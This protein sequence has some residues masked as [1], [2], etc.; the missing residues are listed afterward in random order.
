[1]ISSI[2]WKYP[3]ISFVA[4]LVLAAAPALFRAGTSDPAENHG[5]VSYE[6]V[7]IGVALALIVVFSARY[8]FVATRLVEG[9]D[10]FFYV[11]VARDYLGSSDA[12][13][14]Y[15]PGGYRF[16]EAAMALFGDEL[17]TLQRVFSGV[18]AANALLVAIVLATS[19]RSLAAATLGALWYLVLASRFEG[20]YGTTEPIATLFALIGLLAWGGRPL[21]G[22]AGWWRAISFGAMLG[23]AT[24]TK[25]P[26][27]LLSLGAAALV[28]SLPFARDERRHD[29]GQLT[30][31][32]V[33][34]AVVLVGALLLEG[35]GLLPVRVG[36]GLPARYESI[37]SFAANVQAMLL[38]MGSAQWVT[39]IALVAWAAS[40]A[41]RSLRSMHS[42][43]W[44]A[45]VAFCWLASLASL[46]QFEKRPYLHYALLAAP[47]VAIAVVGM[48]FGMLRFV[49]AR[50]PRASPFAAT[51]FA[52]I[53][54]VPAI[55]P[56]GGPLQIWPLTW[57]P[58]VAH[59]IPWHESADVASDLRELATLVRPGDELLVLPPRHLAVHFLLRNWS[60]S[61][62]RGWGDADVSD[63]ITP[64]LDAVVT[65]H[66]RVLDETDVETCKSMR[67]GSAA[68]LLPERGFRKVA[69]LKAMTL[70][71]RER[72]ATRATGSPRGSADDP[73]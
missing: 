11:C 63:V 40:L 53:L 35:K 42:E 59:G 7:L 68:A 44:A 41:I 38:A 23:L 12:K 70:W 1:M 72:G 10:F 39:L 25:Q 73:R 13:Y 36:L 62:A 5:R 56:T 9:V 46:A 57:N 34:A 69:E 31:I 4:L 3:Y 48:T 65:L 52:G 32:P 33:A 27:G 30:A 61:N 24:W 64:T 50:W 26:A 66:P 14:G 49:K 43:P 18:L 16:W 71:R 29:L 6:R 15:F 60:A 54:F 45:I 8:L 28:L 20:L 55:G 37:G 22:V 2:A 21:R 47:F 67:C 17:P 51:A 58:R 19:W